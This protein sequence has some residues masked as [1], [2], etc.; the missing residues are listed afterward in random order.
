MHVRCPHCHNAIEIVGTTELTDVCCASCGSSFNVYE[1]KTEDPPTRWIGHFQLLQQLGSGGFGTVYKAKD[2]ELDR[3]VAVKI[4]RSGQIGPGEV[5]MFLREARAAAQLKHPQIVAVHE[6]GRDNDTLYIVSDFIQGMTLADRLTAGPLSSRDAAELCA[7]IGD[8]LHHAHEAGVIHRDLKPQNIMLERVSGTDSTNHSPL[9]NHYSPKL[10]D[11]GLA[12]REVG[13]ITMTVDGKIIGTAAY[14]SPEQA[15]GEAHHVDRRTDIYSLGVILFELLT[16]E[17]PFRGNKGMVLNQVIHDDPPS[18]R[19]LNSSVPRDLETIVLKCLERDVQR[20]YSTAADVSAELRRHLSQLPILAR[21]ISTYERTCRWAARNRVVAALLATVLATLLVASAVSTWLAIRENARAIAEATQRQRADREKHLADIERGRAQTAAAEATKQSRRAFRHY[22]TAQMLLAHR[23][24]DF[25]ELDNLH[26]RLAK[27]KPEFTGGDDLR[28]FEWYYWDRLSHSEVRIIQAS[29]DFLGTVAFDHDSRRIATAGWDKTIRVWD[30]TTGRP[31]TTLT[32]HE[33]TINAVAFNHDGTYLASGAWDRSVKVW[34]LQSGRES[35]ALT[36][37]NNHVN[38]VAFN[39]NGTQL[40]S[41]GGDKVKLW[42]FPSGKELR[43]FNHDHEIVISAALAADGA[44]VASGT[45]DT[46]R[47]WDAATGRLLLEKTD[48]PRARV[49]FNQDAS[50]CVAGCSDGVVRVFETATGRELDVYGHPQ[51]DCVALDPTGNWVVSGGRDKEVRLRSVSNKED[52]VFKGHL[53]AVSDISFNRS[54]SHIASAGWDGTV[55]IWDAASFQENR[56]VY[57]GGEVNGVSIVPNS[58]IILIANG[59][60]TVVKWD[61]LKQREALSFE[62]HKSKAT[63]VAINDQG[64]RIVSGGA[65]RIARIWNAVDGELLFELRGHEGDIS[66]VA[67]GLNGTR[68]VSGSDDGTVKTWDSLSGN[69]LATLIGH[70]GA[71]TSVAISSAGTR[72]A[73]GSEDGTARIWDM[74]RSEACHTLPHQSPVMA[75]GFS[76]DG[77][78]IVCGTKQSVVTVWDAQSGAMRHTV[79]G[80]RTP[81]S[82]ALFSEDGSRIF[83]ASMDGVIRS[84]DAKTAEEMMVRNV[85]SYRVTSIAL[86][87]TGTWLVTSST[88][89]TVSLLDG[90]PRSL[91]TERLNLTLFPKDN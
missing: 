47:V 1:I 27:T 39:A 31:L 3:L 90:T 71:V 63:C 13:E 69:E 30:V 11:F 58:S 76:R 59:D 24:W 34:D 56:V 42:Q 15:R 12:K 33:G 87:K 78:Q 28:G 80:H 65:D 25:T 18:P 64:T 82:S 85:Q 49:A 16:G 6:V 17:R 62:A 91:S 26:E 79:K 55:R 54:G 51:V 19:K 66:S 22:Y 8:A 52:L 81:I 43:S 68:V 2:T 77:S 61:V 29:Q 5:E 10:L 83:A 50:R 35:I 53:N 40:M 57:R 67:F 20:R 38:S 73:S 9:A 44:T 86:N 21:P 74:N 89:G 75:V 14:M 4:P 23:D 60:G 72:I 84:W 88:N 46:L 7:Q 32:G 36:G 37:H 48:T 41:A 45:E 70:E